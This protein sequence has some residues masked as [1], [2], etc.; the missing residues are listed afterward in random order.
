MTT[1]VYGFVGRLRHIA[2][3]TKCVAVVGIAAPS[4]PALDI[5][6]AQLPPIDGV[7]YRR[8]ESDGRYGVSV[9]LESEQL[10]A[11]KAWLEPLRTDG[12]CSLLNC[13]RRRKASRHEIDSVAHSIDFG[14]RFELA[15][16]LG[17]IR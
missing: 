13:R 10:D 16:P 9:A 14:P 6:L 12:T 11:L 4:A 8:V 1:T 5:L 17:G 3:G 7:N 15:V 2:H